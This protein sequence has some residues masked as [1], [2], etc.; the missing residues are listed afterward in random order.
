M[1]SVGNV[2][3]SKW[4]PMVGRTRASTNARDGALDGAFFG[5]KWRERSKKSGMRRALLVDLRAALSAATRIVGGAGEVG[6]Q[7]DPIA[8]LAT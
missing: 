4:S 6:A 3:F 7:R 5:V 1:S 8:R 2:P